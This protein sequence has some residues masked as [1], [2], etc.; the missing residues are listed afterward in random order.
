MHDPNS[1]EG[2]VDHGLALD[3]QGR[4][5]E[6]LAEYE[7]ALVLRPDYGRAYCDIGVVKGEKGDTVG[8]IEAYRQS[9]ALNYHSDCPYR[10]LGITLNE[11]GRYAES[12]EVLREG[13][14]EFP[15][16]CCIMLQLAHSLVGQRRFE[17]AI[18]YYRQVLRLQPWR[19]RARQELYVLLIQL[20]RRDEAERARAEWPSY[21]LQH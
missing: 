16:S 21:K 4:Y 19:Q 7:K 5:D 20:G 10:N 9:I 13:L 8:A 18:T 17:E 14:A 2:I 12:E 1:P 6:A 15:N 3:H 11:I